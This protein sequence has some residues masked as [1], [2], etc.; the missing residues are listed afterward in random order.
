MTTAILDKLTFSIKQ[1]N[2]EKKKTL[3]CFSAL[4]S[5]TDLLEYFCKNSNA[6]YMMYCQSGFQY[7]SGERKGC[8]LWSREAIW[9]NVRTL[10]G[11]G[12]DDRSKCKPL[13]SLHQTT[14]PAKGPQMCLW[15]HWLLNW[16]LRSNWKQHLGMCL[17]EK[18]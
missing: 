3:S 11:R 15:K 7:W 1:T 10:W 12:L 16:W 2:K 18:R 8:S 14:E 13:P 6:Y 17:C 4:P 9:T 5:E